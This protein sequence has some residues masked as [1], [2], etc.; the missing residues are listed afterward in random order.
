MILKTTSVRNIVRN[1]L[2]IERGDEGVEVELC[3]KLYNVSYKL[4]LQTSGQ[5]NFQFQACR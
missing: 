4:K 2:K 5:I 1:I 3:N